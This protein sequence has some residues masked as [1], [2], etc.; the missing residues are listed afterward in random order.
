MTALVR[1]YSK[2]I[3]NNHQN[4]FIRSLSTKGIVIFSEKNIE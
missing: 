3:L 2:F 4:Q 1:N